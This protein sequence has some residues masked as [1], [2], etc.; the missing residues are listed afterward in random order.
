VLPQGLSLPPVLD[1]PTVA[2]GRTT[3]SRVRNVRAACSRISSRCA[4]NK[5]RG[6]RPSSRAYCSR[7]N[8]ANQ[9]FP[10]PVA[11]TTSARC[12]PSPRLAARHL[13][14]S[15]WIGCGVG[16]LAMGSNSISPGEGVRAR[17][18]ARL[19]YS[20]THRLSSG[21]AWFQ[22][23]SKL[24]TIRWYAS[25]DASRSV[26]RF[27]SIPSVSAARERLLLPTNAVANPSPSKRQDFG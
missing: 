12:R 2:F 1:H 25:G 10:S 13:N 6:K 15:C 4:T 22:S 20:A 11:M 26:L 5:T 23:A 3:L 19:A 27:H 16:T 7:S 14:A 9:V 21:R 24:S 17:L 8:A 18:R